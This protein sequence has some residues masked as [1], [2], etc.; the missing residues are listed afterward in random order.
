[1]CDIA[2]EPLLVA[3]RRG[4]AG[5]EAVKRGGKA[6]ELVARWAEVETAVEVV[7]APLL[8]AGGHL[9]DRP[10]RAAERA[11]YG[12]QA[13][14]EHQSARHQRAEQDLLLEALDGLGRERDDHRPHAP[15]A[16]LDRLERSLTSSGPSRSAPPPL[17][18][19][20]TAT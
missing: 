5:Q 2:R 10:Q 9:G 1:M 6:A 20:S 15:A 13:G 16:G 18:P 19:S 3:A 4:Y 7:L 14:E 11:A 8:D 12:K 17:R